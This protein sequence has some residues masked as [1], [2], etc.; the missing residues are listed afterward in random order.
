MEL[1]SQNP[2]VMRG[3]ALLMFRLSTMSRP[4]P[5]DPAAVRDSVFSLAKTPVLSHEDREKVLL[6]VAGK[7]NSSVSEVDNAI[8]ADNEVSGKP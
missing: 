1:K 8:Y 6:T 4:S 3:L 5:L 7:F 2:K